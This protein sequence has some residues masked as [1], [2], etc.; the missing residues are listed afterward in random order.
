[1]TSSTVSGL[2]VD[3]DDLFAFLDDVEAV[4]GVIVL[5]DIVEAL[6]RA[7]VIVELDARRDHVDEGRASVKDRGF[8]QRDELG[9]VAGKAAGDETGAELQALW[10]TS[11]ITSWFMIPRLDFEPLSDVAENWPL[12]RPYTPLFSTM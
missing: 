10:P 4:H 9:L 12:V 6:G 2:V 7:D 5:A 3:V 11:S 8:D 1:M